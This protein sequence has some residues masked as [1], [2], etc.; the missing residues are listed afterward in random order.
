L[1]GQEAAQKLLI[2]VRELG[3]PMLLEEIDVEPLATR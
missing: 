2:L 3:V 1:C